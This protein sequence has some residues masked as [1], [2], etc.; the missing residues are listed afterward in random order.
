MR[1]GN[2]STE[3]SLYGKDKSEYVLLVK[4]FSAF[5]ASRTLIT[6]SLSYVI[7]LPSIYT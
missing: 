5:Y 3:Q 2:N 7:I 4:K 1:N 6:M